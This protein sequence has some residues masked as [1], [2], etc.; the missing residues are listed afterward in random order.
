[1]TGAWAEVFHVD[2]MSAK[3]TNKLAGSVDCDLSNFGAGGI[4]NGDRVDLLGTDNIDL[5]RF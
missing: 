5:N 2:L 1:V 4:V 3:V